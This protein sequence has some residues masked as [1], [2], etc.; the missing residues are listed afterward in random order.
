[1]HWLV[2]SLADFWQ[3]TGDTEEGTMGNTRTGP[4]VRLEFQ[5]RDCWIGVFWKRSEAGR[6]SLTPGRVVSSVR[7]VM[8]TDVWICLV[9]MLPLHIQWWH[10]ETR[11]VGR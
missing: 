11:V 8:Q 2:W 5:P 1:M 4:V 3:V 7:V 9:P 6:E 10:V